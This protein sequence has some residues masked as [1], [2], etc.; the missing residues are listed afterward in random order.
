MIFSS[1]FTFDTAG[2]FLQLLL[3]LKMCTCTFPVA[4]LVPVRN[5]LFSTAPL[6]EYC[7]STKHFTCQSKGTE[8]EISSYDIEEQTAFGSSGQQEEIKVWSI[9]WRGW[10]SAHPAS[11]GYRA[12]LI[13]CIPLST[14]GQ[15]WA[16]KGYNLP[17]LILHPGFSFLQ[18]LM[19]GVKHLKWPSHFVPSFYCDSRFSFFLEQFQYSRPFLVQQGLLRKVLSNIVR[20]PYLIKSH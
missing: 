13:D 1:C 7:L 5:L 8:E 12:R 15:K 6:H 4:V 14:N 2:V 17:D 18:K 16:F 3:C 20:F 19:L 10:G 11:H 9:K